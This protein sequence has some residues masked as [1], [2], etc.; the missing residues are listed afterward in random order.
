MTLRGRE[1]VADWIETALVVRGSQPIGL[2]PLHSFFEKYHGLE[3]QRVNV[4]LREMERRARLLGERYPFKIHGEY[5]VQAVSGAAQSVYI[6]VTLMAP[7]G[8]VREYIAQ[9]PDETMAVGFEN[10]TVDAVSNLWGDAGQ[11]LRFGW[12]SDIGRPP[13]F[14]LAIRWLAE[15]VGVEVGQGYRQPRRKD[16]GVDVVSWRPF[17]D[18]RPGFPLVLVQ[19]TL[20]DNLLA[21]GMDIDA[22]LW[23]SW[24]SMDFDP[25][26]AIATPAALAAG[27]TWDELAL[28]YLVLDRIRLVGLTKAAS[29]D[30]LTQE[31]VTQ[32]IRELTIHMEE[33]GEL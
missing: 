14:D 9:A 6:A 10:V 20:Q 21:K 30:E 2:D 19:C 5:A 11:A 31:W 22:R 18:G 12:P 15:K 26:T 1:R 7:G 27:P 33:I 16:G 28:K 17:P 3:P 24:L 25:I 23:S 4:G 32:V 8:A 29:T 13:E